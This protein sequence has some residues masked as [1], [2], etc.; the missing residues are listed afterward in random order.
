V[1]TIRGLLIGHVVIALFT[2]WPGVLVLIASAVARRN[3]CALDEASAHSCVVNGMEVGD[4]LSS[5]YAMG[6]FM[7]ATIPI[8]VVAVVAWTVTWLIWWTVKRRKARRA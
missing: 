3:G 5:M 8:G 2:I 1:R 4:A 6:W 7:I